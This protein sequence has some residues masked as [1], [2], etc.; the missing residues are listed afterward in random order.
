MPD[1]GS[2]S[3]RDDPWIER[4]VHQHWG[5]NAEKGYPVLEDE[6]TCPVT[7]H[8]HVEGNKYDACKICTLAN[9]YFIAFKESAWKDKDASKKNKEFG[10]KYQAIIPVWCVNSP[11]WEG[12]NGKMKVIMFND[13]KFYQEFRKKVERA[14]MQAQANGYSVFNGTNAV[15][16]C[17]HVTEEAQVV[18]QGQPNE[19][20]F[21]KKVID[22]VVFSTKPYDIP[23][24]T[25]EAIKEMDF[26][27]EYYT[28]S[29]PA[30]ID[31][32]YR[33][34]CTVSND[35]IPADDGIQAFEAPA[36]AAAPAAPAMDNPAAK[37]VDDLPAGGID[38]LV[39]SAPA[40]TAPAA[41]KPTDDVSAEDLL[42]GLNL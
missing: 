19:Y 4:F 32:F 26:D 1:A 40:P 29:S 10:R 22:K 13:K 5:V 9:K 18:N 7:P 15:D 39:D 25:S 30:E 34:W 41:A 8:V 33:K 11:S 3:D 37:P 36:P 24:I 14:Q 35:D 20:T 23:Q 6:I 21:K 38:D 12:D 2:G 28:T 17:I 16:C 27:G 42:A 31:A